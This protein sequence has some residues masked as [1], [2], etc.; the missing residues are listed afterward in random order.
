VPIWHEA[1]R[2]RPPD[3]RDFFSD[4]SAAVDWPASAFWRELSEAHPAAI[5]ILSVRDNA[6][7]WWQSADATILQVVRAEPPPEQLQW[8]D[9]VLDL[10]AARLGEG[11]RDPEVAMA[12]YERHS[13]EVRATVPA[14]RLVEWNPADGWAPIC[15]ALGVAA[16]DEPF[17]H[18]NT[19]AEWEERR[20]AE[21]H[22]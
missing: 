2:G 3:W 11:W 8:R 18:V 1:L 4:W 19:T 12:A 13:D 15:R 9:F 20:A 14:D 5:V 22:E 16:P 17:P 21:G 10:F 7:V 6:E